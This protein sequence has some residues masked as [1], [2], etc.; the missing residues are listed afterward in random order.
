MN[1]KQY[2][3]KRKILFLH[4]FMVFIVTGLIVRLVDTQLL[5]GNLFAELATNN[6]MYVV[7]QP[8]Q[9][10]VLLDRYSDPLVFNKPIY[11][12]LDSSESLY[13]DKVRI[14]RDEALKLMSDDPDAI[15]IEHEREYRYP[16]STSHILGYIGHVTSDDLIQD[17]SLKISDKI[18]KMGL[19]LE[20]Q[21]YL[22]GT[23]GFKKFEINAMGEKQHLVV[24]EDGVPGFS[25]KTTIDPYLSEVALK[26]LGEKLG[27]VVILDGETGDVLALVSTPTFDLSYFSETEDNPEGE[28]ERVRKIQSFFS[29]PQKL[30][31]NRAVSGAYPPGSV[32]KLVTAM[33]GLEND[34]I[35]NSTTV[36]DEGVLK[37]GEYSYANWYFTQHGKVEG[38]INLQKSIARSNDIY[39]YKVAEWVGPEKIK[40]MAELFG[41]G[42]KTGIQLQAESAGLIP[43]PEWKQRILG[44]RWFLGNTY[45]FGIGQG[46]LLAS[47]IQ[48]AQMVQG[49]TNK[50]TL[51]SPSIV[52]DDFR[53]GYL[54]DSRCGEV[55]V[56]RENLDIV[57]K[58]MLDACSDGG[59]GF[60]FFNYNSL[61]RNP[62]LNP[63]EEINKGAVACKTGTSEFG[64]ADER[65]YRKTHAWFAA[66]FGTSDLVSELNKIDFVEDDLSDENGNSEIDEGKLNQVIVSADLADQSEEK[67][68]NTQKE[69]WRK[70]IKDQGL[71]KNLVIVVLVES[72]E[73]NPYR[74]G[75]KDAGP[76]AKEIFD[77]MFADTTKP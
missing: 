10:G 28:L 51:C 26:A 55:G 11:Y 34:K 76:V 35:T 53:T 62:S 13:S 47:P 3:P 70:N 15:R 74:E 14:N 30:F 45:H 54:K 36:K 32:F 1:N 60:P 63:Y 48:V 5:K 56:L 44:E 29:H 22:K 9:R 27:S 6:R 33:A 8:E 38:D 16:L 23:K 17:S 58:G 49:I 66:S 46:D 61:V 20:M 64:G 4:A 40:E 41:F 67:Q 31:F 69:T 25:V 50:G 65:G 43:D 12:K 59:T 2:S 21:D 39:F 73:V 57:I 19:E 7:N 72:D 77:W 52:S 18:G 71:P 37:V 42:K 68:Q 75:S 24:K